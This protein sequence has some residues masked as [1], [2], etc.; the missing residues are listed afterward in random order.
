MNVIAVQLVVEARHDHRTHVL[1][2]ET[3]G[4]CAQE[5][6]GFFGSPK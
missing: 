6:A 1:V 5:T 4:Q 2:E 3:V